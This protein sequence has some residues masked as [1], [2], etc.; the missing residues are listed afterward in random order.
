MFD[1]DDPWYRPL[2]RR[3]L[4]CAAALGWGVFELVSGSPG[5]AIPFLA[6]GAFATYHLLVAFD[7]GD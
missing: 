2:W 6:A 4:V 3:V 1:F 7:P 5:W